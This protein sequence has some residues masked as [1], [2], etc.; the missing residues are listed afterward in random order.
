MA[1]P[2]AVTMDETPQAAN[3]EAPISGEGVHSPH[4]LY[5]LGSAAPH[6]D[7][8][9]LPSVVLSPPHPEE[10]PDPVSGPDDCM[11]VAL[12]DS[13][14]PVGLDTPFE[15][16]GKAVPMVPTSE[17][18]FLDLIRKAAMDHMQ[19]RVK[20]FEYYSFCFSAAVPH[21]PMH[22]FSSWM[23][24]PSTLPLLPPPRQCAIVTASGIDGYL[25]SDTDVADDEPALPALAIT[26]TT[27]PL[28]IA[29]APETTLAL[30][31]GGGGA[32]IDIAK[33]QPVHDG[34][35]DGSLFFFFRSIHNH[36]SLQRTV[37]G[38]GATSIPSDSLAVATHALLA[39]E[40]ESRQVA[41]NAA[42]RSD[43]YMWVPPEKLSLEQWRG[44]I[45][46]WDEASTQFDL[47]DLVIDQS[48]RLVLKTCS[49]LVHSSAYESRATDYTLSARHFACMHSSDPDILACLQSLQKLTP[50]L[51]RQLYSLD[52]RSGWIFTRDGREKL[53]TVVI[54]ESPRPFFTPLPITQPYTWTR[55]EILQHLQVTHWRLEFLP[56]RKR[57]KDL[58]TYNGGEHAPRI[59]YLR[60]NP[61][62]IPYYYILCLASSDLLYEKALLP[63]KH[64]QKS[65]YYMDALALAYPGVQIE[66]IKGTGV[67]KRHPGTAAKDRLKITN[68]SGLDSILDE[69]EPR[70]GRVRG[71]R[72]RG[73]RRPQSERVRARA[74]PAPIQDM[75]SEAAEASESDGLPT[76]SDDNDCNSND[77]DSPS[78]SDG[79][80]GGDVPKSDPVPVPPDPVPDPDPVA[81][82][83][84]PDPGPPPPRSNSGSGRASSTSSNS[85]ST[86]T[87]GPSSD[88]ESRAKRTRVPSAL[89]HSWGKFFFSGR[90]PTA[91][92]KGNWYCLCPYHE[93]SYASSGRPTVCGRSR[94]FRTVEEGMAVLMDLRHWASKACDF[95]PDNRHGH[96]HGCDLRE[97][98]CPSVRRLRKRR[99][100][101]VAQL[102]H[103]SF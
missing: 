75:E 90:S 53:R 89:S 85:S 77:G 59:W 69:P 16:L 10:G 15:S 28:P 95:L 17:D 34:T 54:L 25:D 36:P 3:L 37:D 42:S 50:P 86:T 78:T 41:L 5:S 63:L 13:D 51:A 49:A 46:Q 19:T 35:H 57:V 81:D 65:K 82:P 18:F 88:S 66:G 8:A 91:T 40:A 44:S 14:D 94:G 32:D 21:H 38:P 22:T 27:G 11:I 97:E 26:D 93:P 30:P 33:F 4:S 48:H 70:Q 74:A 45:Q 62:T 73:R 71:G 52:D 79:A 1:A 2:S 68:A 80:G 60:P 43:Q 6:V 9:D 102:R 29:D 72:V 87:D 23:A 58:P 99:E 92:E 24:R 39:V 61:T 96:V 84:L 83:V 31:T 98:D 76:N 20:N 67:K 47:R 103:V 7:D 56:P 12:S 64:L 101:N 100:R 55:M